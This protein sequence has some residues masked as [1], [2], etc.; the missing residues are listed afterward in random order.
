MASNYHSEKSQS[1]C[2]TGQVSAISPT[3]PKHEIALGNR[4]DP[5]SKCGVSIN[6]DALKIKC[7][8]CEKNLS[9]RAYRFKHHLAG[10]SQNVAVCKAVTHEVKQEMFQIVNDRVE[11]SRK[12][13]L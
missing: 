2:A 6:G 4:T 10:T 1:A 5:S 9:G 12:C 11:F 3:V 13:F 8:F 7:K